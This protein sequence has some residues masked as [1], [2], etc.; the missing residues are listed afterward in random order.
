[1]ISTFASH[2]SKLSVRC[3]RS[4]GMPSRSGIITVDNIIL[5][6][7]YDR[8]DTDLIHVWARKPERRASVYEDDPICTVS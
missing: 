8:S 7:E 2:P 1:M 3:V 4:W 6:I 5:N